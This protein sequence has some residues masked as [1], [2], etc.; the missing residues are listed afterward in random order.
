MAFTLS[1]ILIVSLI[2]F[3]GAPWVPNSLIKAVVGNPVGVFVILVACLMALRCSLL[4]GLAA[5]LAAGAL[6]LQNRK[7]ILRQVEQ[8]ASGDAQNGVR[9]S[10]PATVKSLDVPA[11]DLIDGEVHPPHDEPSGEGHAYE[12]TD[13]GKNEFKA[14]DRTIN[15]KEVLETQHGNTDQ[16]VE[17]FLKGNF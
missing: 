7:R 13:S 4:D 1:P 17:S 10:T 8:G 16:K 15:E 11:D 2:V 9:V 5:F 6:F 3:L 12:P 14:V